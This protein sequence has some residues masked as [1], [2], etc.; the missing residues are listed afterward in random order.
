MQV[1]TVQNGQVERGAA[2][3]IHTLSNGMTIPVVAVGEEGRGRKQAMI[4]V[5]NAPLADAEAPGRLLYADLGTTKSGGAKLI[6]R[7][8]PGTADT[9]AILVFRTGIG[10]RGSNAHTG[11]RAGWVCQKFATCR[12]EGTGA[13]PAACPK[14]GGTGFDLTFAPF[15][16]RVLATGVIAQ[17][18]AGNMGS[19]EQIIAVMPRGVVFRTAYSGRLYGEPADHYYIF[20]GQQ[21]LAVTWGERMATD[22]L[23]PPPYNTPRPEPVNAVSI[24]D[25]LA[26]AA[27]LPSGLPDPNAIQKLAHER[28]ELQAAL[29]AGD[30]PGAFTEVADV[31]YYAIKAI[32]EAASAAGLTVEQALAVC[33]AKYRLRARPGNPKDDEAERAAVLAVLGE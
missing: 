32:H 12:K 31:A 13:P 23:L 7:Q 21:V 19:G 15:P 29:V 16:G 18:N 27:R 20:D 30:M 25:V 2:L 4:P 17:G 33:E 9:E 8:E 14:C 28:G 24:A 3:H 5:A 10:F 1:F 11:D 22:D 26:L 6:A